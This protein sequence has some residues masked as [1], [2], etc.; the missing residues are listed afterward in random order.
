MSTKRVTANGLSFAY[1]EEGSGPLVLMFH[2]FPDTPHTW[3][4]VRPKIAAKGY[5]V[6][7]PFMRGYRPTD[8]PSRDT[9]DETLARD[10]LGL[11]DALGEERAIIVGHDWG[12]SAVY[13][14]AALDSSRVSKLV[15][16]AIPHPATL[17]PTPAKL[18]AARHFIAY[19]IPGAASRFARNDFAALPAICKRWSPE[20]TPSAEEL[21]PVRECFA[22]RASLDAAFGY[23]RALRFSAPTWLR[24]KIP[25]PTIVFSGT[26]DPSVNRADYEKARR[27]FTGDYTIEEIPGGH[28]MHREHPDAFARRLLAH[29]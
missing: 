8:I 14:A 25:V 10:V 16:V 29:L 27:M 20:W 21:A 5:R 2:G 24:A 9:N 12:A 19:K 26:G 23:Y 17:A 18:W 7:T 4:D 6:V 22:D 1:I 13:G 3:D 15:A 28:F 11:V